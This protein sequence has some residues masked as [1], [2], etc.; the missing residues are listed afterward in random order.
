[1]LGAAEAMAATVVSDQFQQFEPMGVSGVVVISESH[2][3]IHTW[4]EHHYAAVD[5]FSC[6]D[7]L[8]LELARDHLA[9]AFEA[10]RV[11]HEEHERGPDTTS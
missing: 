2:L 1:M 4:P 6:D 5:F 11:E 7:D 9:E 8:D 3:A 10:E